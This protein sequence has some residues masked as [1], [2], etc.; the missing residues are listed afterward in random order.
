MITIKSQLTEEELKTIKEMYEAELKEARH[1]LEQNGAELSKKHD[2]QLKTAAMVRDLT[3]KL[4][5]LCKSL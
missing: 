5:F 2:L 4:V 1:L 3:S